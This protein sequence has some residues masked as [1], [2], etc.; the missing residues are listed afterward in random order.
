M[1]RVMDDNRNQSLDL[2]EFSKGMR[3]FGVECD[4]ITVFASLDKNKSETVDFD[5]L[6]IALRVSRR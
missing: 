4:V 5:E 2:A 1:F 6:L 3:D